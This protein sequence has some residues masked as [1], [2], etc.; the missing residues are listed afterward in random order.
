[1][2]NYIK[3]FLLINLF[4]HIYCLAISSYQKQTNL[5]Y[6][7]NL[8]K[9]KEEEN[10][11]MSDDIVI[12]HTNDVHVGI[13]DN[14]G[15][16]G[17]LLYK[18]ELQKKYKNVI[19]V[20]VGDHNRGGIIGVISKG[21]VI[22]DI[23]NY[24]GYDV[25][26][27]GNH[28]FDFGIDQIERFNQTLKSGYI[29]A[30]FCYR[31]NKTPIF[32]P[33]KIVNAG[34]QK[35]G[36]IGV[37]T[38][39]TLIKTNI[40]TI[41]NKDGKRIYD[42]LSDNK[43]QELYDT[44]QKYINELKKEKINYIVI[45]AHL[46][47]I[48]EPKEFNIVEFVSHLNKVDAVLDAH[49]HQIYSFFSKDKDGKEIP[50]IQAGTKLNAFGVLKITKKG[51]ISSKIIFEV[52]PPS[53][54]NQNEAKTIIRN[55]KERWVDVGLNKKMNEYFEKY[56]NSL[57]QIIG[58]SNYSLLVSLDDSGDPLK[59]ISLTQESNLC[60]LVTDAIRA[61]GKTDIS[62]INAGNMRSNLMK[63]NITYQNILEI[64]P[65]LSKII[66]KEVLGIDILDA[67]EFGT[68]NLP[69][70]KPGFPQVSGISFKVNPNLKS[71]VEIDGDGLFIKINGKR[72]VYDV[73]VNGEKL[74][75]NKKYKIAFNLY[76]GNGGD[77]YSMFVKYKEYEELPLNDNEIL[78]K[79]IKEDLK[80]SIPSFYQETQGRIIIVDKKKEIEKIKNKNSIKIQI[81][82]YFSNVMPLILQ[83][84]NKFYF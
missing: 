60:N 16:D 52:P 45:L 5:Y 27:L 66:I 58:Y 28:E 35:I 48:D 80:G 56:T 81:I 15:Y 79:Y 84:L 21:S 30:N 54:K 53:E 7:K 69:G 50:I 42:F 10:E 25:A 49:T 63:G 17:L 19:T 6:K 40:H 36:F 51:K 2:N 38:P 34:E 31:E 24:I 44:I 18:K 3:L 65:F 83:L 68:K 9:A 13:M 61:Y 43:G 29:C 33:Y 47:N 57:N 73:M 4:I 82:N 59:Q 1:M 41:L 23:M 71:N 67:L 46:G 12:I 64:L 26:I 11:E 14:I 78:I 55:N 77:G 8:R 32:P 39:T 76:L 75:L 74:D 22:M 70:M 72:R 62:I 37:V 20:D